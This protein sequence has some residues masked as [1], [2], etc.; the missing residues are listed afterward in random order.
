MTYM[1]GIQPRAYWKE[2]TIRP[3][4]PKAWNHAAVEQVHLGLNE[5]ANVLKLDITL[6]NTEDVYLF[7][8]DVKGWTVKLDLANATNARILLDGVEASAAQ[9][10]ESVNGSVV[11]IIPG[12]GLREVRVQRA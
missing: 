7:S 9:F 5:P 11:L 10:M 2:L 8:L 1:L 4:L 6:S 12:T 3:R